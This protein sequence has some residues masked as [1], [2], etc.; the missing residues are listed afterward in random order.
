MKKIETA[1]IMKLNLNVKPCIAMC[2]SILTVHQ[3][4][5]IPLVMFNL[6]KRSDMNKGAFTDLVKIPKTEVKT[7]QQKDHHQNVFGQDDIY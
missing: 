6:I 2:R 1:T 5:Y 3:R 4:Q 7:F